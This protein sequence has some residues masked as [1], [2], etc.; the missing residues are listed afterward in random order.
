MSLLLACL[1]SDGNY[2][3]VCV[4][5]ARRDGSTV[6]VGSLNGTPE[7]FVLRAAARRFAVSSSTALDFVEYDV[8][9]RRFRVSRCS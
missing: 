1:D 8:Y 6:A 9:G 3:R 2:R 7:A 4:R 5:R